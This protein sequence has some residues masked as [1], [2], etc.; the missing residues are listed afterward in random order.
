MK[1]FILENW[2]EL[3]VGLMA[4]AK[5]IINLTPSDADNKVFSYIDKVFDYFIP[6]YKK[7]GEAN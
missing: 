5:I 1:N 6:N 2:L 3:L 7:D 4:F